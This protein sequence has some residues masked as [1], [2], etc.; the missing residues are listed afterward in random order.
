MTARAYETSHPWI[1]FALPLELRGTP[2]LWALLGQCQAKFEQLA[3]VLIDP[4]V[5]SKLTVMYIVRGAAAS[6]QIE[7]NPLTEEHLRAAIDHRGDVPQA[8]EYHQREQLN[9]V[10]ACN[11]FVTTLESG[12]RLEISVD[13]IKRLNALVLQG[14]NY[15]EEV[16]PGEISQH[17]VV[18]ADVYRGAPRSDCLYLLDRLCEFLRSDDFAMGEQFAMAE[19]ILRALVAHL[20]LAWIHAFGDG[21]GRT[22][23]LMEVQILLNAGV[24]VPAAHLLSNHYNTTRE[25]YRRELDLASKTRRIVPFLLY[26]LRGLVNELAEQI[27]EVRSYQREIIWND[28]LR[29]KFN[30]HQK[31]ERRRKELMRLIPRVG[32]PFTTARLRKLHP[33]IETLYA[34]LD[35]K[36]ISRD[37]NALLERG[38]LR[39]APNGHLIADQDVLNAFAVR[40]YPMRPPVARGA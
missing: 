37:V 11:A 23:R 13:Q 9:I 33:A 14:T 39:P 32:G 19:A 35:Q 5:A 21:N 25:A 6:T 34:G 30:D 3:G 12:K 20:Y 40:Q 15:P 36:T 1:T 22:A 10:E 24:P 16:V 31:P 27:T 29:T 38:L 4:A 26:A 18:V 17:S 7:G 28:F 2:E 8:H